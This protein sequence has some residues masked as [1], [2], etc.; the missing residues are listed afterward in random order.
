MANFRYL[1]VDTA[2]SDS[3]QAEFISRVGEE[4]QVLGKE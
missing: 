2:A 1:K 4:A 3:M